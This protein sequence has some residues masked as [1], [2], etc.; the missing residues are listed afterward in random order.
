M[1]GMRFALALFA[2]A[3]AGCASTQIYPT[4]PRDLIARL[5]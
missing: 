4:L 2:V 5:P 1:P 3:L